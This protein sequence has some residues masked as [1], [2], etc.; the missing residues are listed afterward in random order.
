MDDSQKLDY[1]IS[2]LE[3]LTTSINAINNTLEVISKKLDI[4]G[5][6]I[7]PPEDDDN[8]NDKDI[9]T[10]SSKN[11]VIN[12]KPGKIINYIIKPNGLQSKDVNVYV[13]GM[14]S[15][16]MNKVE[17][18]KDI[19]IYSEIFYKAMD[20]FIT[21]I[22]IE[23]TITGKFSNSIQFTVDVMGE[24][25]MTPIKLSTKK[26]N[27]FCNEGNVAEL[28]GVITGVIDGYCNVYVNGN[29]VGFLDNIENGSEVVLYSEI[30]T[31]TKV[32]KVYVEYP[33]GNK[34]E[35]IM[36]NIIINQYE[37]E[38]NI[39]LTIYTEEPQISTY[40][41]NT[42]SYTASIRGLN[43]DLINVYVNDL[44]RSTH[45]IDASTDLDLVVLYEEDITL[46]KYV[47]IYIDDGE[48]NVSNA[49][50]YEVTLINS[51]DVEQKPENVRKLI[52][53][54]DDLELQ[55][56]LGEQV[57][58]VAS[59]SGV[60]GD[61]CN[62]Y[63]NGL[64][65]RRITLTEDLNNVTLYSFTAEEDK[66]FELQIEDVQGLL[67]NILR[68][69][70]HIK[71]EDET[72]A[73]DEEKLLTPPT[74]LC[75][76]YTKLIGGNR[77]TWT[78]GN[79][80]L[81]SD[82]SKLSINSITL[83]VRMLIE[84]VTSIN[85]SIDEEDLNIVKEAML[86]MKSQG[87]LTKV[88]V[89]LEPCPCINSGEINEREF[90][91]YNQESFITNW[92]NEIIR[93][94]N[95][96][97]DYNFWGIYVNTNMDILYDNVL[98]WQEIYDTIKA[99]R[100]DSNIMIKT[101]WWESDEDGIMMG[102]N[103]KSTH[104]YFRIW[105]VV[106]ISAYFPL[107]SKAPSASYNEIYGWINNGTDHTNQQIKTDIRAFAAALNKPI[108]FGE[109]GIPALDN[110]VVEPYNLQ[111]G[112]V[113]DEQTQR[114][115]YEAWH[116]SFIDE[117]WFLGWHFYHMSDLYNSPYDPTDKSSALFIASLDIIN[118]YKK[119]DY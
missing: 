37:T 95:E 64:F 34:S 16:N 61:W 14:Y 71:E 6:E 7:A 73:P 107:A 84:D 39:P 46:N 105:D 75:Q 17:N 28:K 62:V 89:I 43:S 57:D 25:I 106:S 111:C 15:H 94:L 100:P 103:T 4:D 114:N 102:L 76:E 99:G 68:F 65:N 82:I 86:T 38:E 12:V 80:E 110:A 29:Y 77:S 45:Y 119:I 91:P 63:I 21:N 70:I 33:D 97:K 74:L 113:E 96:L 72:P 87:I 9:V 101:N 81:I 116:N 19:V 88:Q 5:G 85:V 58:C 109:L 36:Y 20:D 27:V 67:S 40:S 78:R 79:Q 24:A 23:D 66:E 83:S 118:K 52:I 42:V 3:G 117:D 10:I 47:Y 54:S 41:G 104:P 112:Y 1:I 92:R 93:L 31:E 11:E 55:P 51:N 26:H 115:W 90:N 44:Y 2:I 32:L 60:I 49:I 18:D 59:I 30:A 13:N 108:M 8:E 48:G 50:T 35:E 98:L 22:M 69:C 56:L 53:N